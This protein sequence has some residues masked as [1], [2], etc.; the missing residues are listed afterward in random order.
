MGLTYRLNVYLKSWFLAHEKKEHINIF[1]DKISA[2][3]VAFYDSY[4]LKSGKK[5]ITLV[6]VGILENLR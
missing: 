6:S 5:S 2:I 4:G 3:S 1:P